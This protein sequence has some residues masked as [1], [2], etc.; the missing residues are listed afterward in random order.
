[1]TLTACA[2]CGTHTNPGTNCPRCGTPTPTTSDIA[3][4]SGYA[5]YWQGI[6][7]RLRRAAA[8]K[9]DV[10]GILGY[11]GMAGVFLAHEP[12]LGRKVAI[13]VMSPALMIDPNLV[14]RF[15]QEARTIAHLSHQNIVTIFEV[16][17]REDLHWFAMAHVPGRTL[18]EVMNEATEPLSIPVVGA[19]LHQ[20][21]DALAYA[22]QQGVVHRDIKP[23]NVLLDLRGNALVTDFGIAKV[24]DGEKAGLTR[25]GMLVGT[26]TYMSPEQCSSG[27][28]GGASDQYSLGAVVY[29]MLTGSAPFAGPT[30]AVIQAHL[31]QQPTPIQELR[32]D[33]PDEL[34]DSIHRMLEKAPEHRWPTMSAAIA[35][36]GAVAPGIDD[37][38]RQ[39]L[40]ALAAPT[41]SISVRQTQS[42]LREGTRAAFAI[43]MVDSHGRA[44]SGRRLTWQSSDTTIADVE[45]DELHALSPGSTEIVVSSGNAQAT[46][47]VHIEPDPIG[48]ISVR[49]S[50]LSLREGSS[51]TVEAIVLDID[52]SRLEDRAVLWRSSNPAVAR[53]NSMGVVEGLELGQALVAARTGG[54]FATATV[55]VTAA[56][57]GAAPE[58]G[59]GR[60]TPATKSGLQTRGSTRQ[61]VP[62][63][64]GASSAARGQTKAPVVQTKRDAQEAVG[65]LSSKLPVLL[66]AGILVLL[67]GVLFVVQPWKGGSTQ[68]APTASAARAFI[69]VATAIPA[70]GSVKATDASGTVYDL[71]RDATDLEPGTYT[72]QFRADGYQPLDS[73]VAVQEGDTLVWSPAFIAA[74]IPT[75]DAQKDPGA[76]VANGAI[77]VGG[78]LPAGAIVQAR[79]N[80]TNT[81]R[82]LGSRETQVP[83][84]SYTLEFQA[85][86]YERSDSVIVLRSGQSLVWHPRV[87]EVAAPVAAAR[88]ATFEVRGNVPQGGSIIARGDGRNYPITGATVL[89]PGTY[90]VEFTAPGYDPDRT[91]ITLRAGQSETWTPTMRRTEVKAAPPVDVRADQAAIRQV[92]EDY[93]ARFHSREAAAAQ[94]LPADMRSTW[95]ALFGSNVTN[96]SATLS[97]VGTPT[98]NGENGMVQFTLNVSF[99]QGGPEQKSAFTFLGTMQRASGVWRI[100]SLT[101]QNE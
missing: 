75:P 82:L 64:A 12:R 49:P 99:R 44:I 77:S 66:G 13:K 15:E 36:A 9:Y 98:V 84:G 14:D 41:A 30:L 1:M 6:L 3:P 88:D 17:Q 80:A 25:T 18:G 21:A 19:W 24:A 59:I 48:D 2:N 37:P 93:R 27:R 38:V 4:Q 35:A 69:S 65:A 32:P 29:Q 40:E 56:P 55:T 68:G 101:R 96:F 74:A 52:G 26:P 70:N 100:A 43:T 39:E 47:A 90:T 91:T 31:T 11:G 85:P 57:L 83:P 46:V 7:E 81:P 72:L 60:A 8:P 50:E 53:V 78:S 61:T 71:S 95:T 34:A 79:D 51:A 54:K 42:V 86:G 28:V 62:A 63:K 33:C 87:R 94:L 73:T 89:P 92:V 10:K 20:I 58:G 16:D 45:M 67:L 5:T 23:G 76:V 97:N 22:H